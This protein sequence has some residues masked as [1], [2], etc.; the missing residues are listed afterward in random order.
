MTQVFP[1]VNAT[2][3][4][5]NN[6]ALFN[7]LVERVVNRPRHLPGMASFHG[8]SGYG[9]TFSATYAANKYRAYYVE[10]GESWTKAKFCRALLTELGA[11]TRGT[12]ADMVDRI[13]EHL[14]INERPVIIDEFDHVVARRYHETIREIHDKTGAP[15]ILIG[16]ELLPNKLATTSERFHNRMLDWVPAQPA[17]ADDAR[18]LARLY[19]PGLEIADDLLE[20]ITR[21][22]EGRVRRICV[23][24][25]RVRETAGLEGLERIDLATW[26]DRPL[27]S[28]KPPARRG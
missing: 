5:L 27:F 26:G 14:V 10:V 24:L 3:A 20:L 9:K 16:E 25:E 12:I 13:I 1:G 21:R 7:E 28:G 19:C 8:F 11:D 18:A 6:V 23:N 4:P 15:I 2:I 22:S 17:D